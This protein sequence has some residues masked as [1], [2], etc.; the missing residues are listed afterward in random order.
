MNELILQPRQSALSLD[1]YEKLNTLADA[2]FSFKPTFTSSSMPIKDD[3]GNIVSWEAAIV[4]TGSTLQI[5]GNPDRRL[6]DALQRPAPAGYIVAHLTRLGAH[7]RHT[8]GAAAFTIVT[9]DVARDMAGM[10][11]WAVVKTCE[12]FRHGN[13]PFFPD[14]PEL[15]ACLKKWAERADSFRVKEENVKPQQEETK[16]Q[17]TE[18]KRTVKQKRRVSKLVKLATKAK[19]N[20]SI[21]ERKFFTAMGVSRNV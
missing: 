21:W 9:E 12:E 14:T 13:K 19:N 5:T 17:Q 10:S 16:V 11:E 4:E 7:L 15:I 20:W 3:L 2:S 18:R 6:V 1:D 8:K